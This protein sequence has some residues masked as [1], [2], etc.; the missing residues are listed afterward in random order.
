MP[1][2]DLEALSNSSLVL[3]D[4]K[5][6]PRVTTRE[7]MAQLGRLLVKSFPAFYGN[8]HGRSIQQHQEAEGEPGDRLTRC[9]I[10]LHLLLPS[11]A[12]AAMRMAL[13]H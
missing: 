3:P 1:E 13:S 9:E 4:Y 5:S 8:G 7:E 11:L 2:S 6:N 10:G 12:V